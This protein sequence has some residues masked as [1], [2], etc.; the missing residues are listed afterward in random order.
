VRVFGSAERSVRCLAWSWIP[1]DCCGSVPVWAA[2]SGKALKADDARQRSDPDHLAL[3]LHRVCSIENRVE[4]KGR[5]TA[6]NDVDDA[7]ATVDPQLLGAGDVVNREFLP[8]GQSTPVRYF[9]EAQDRLVGFL[10]IRD[11]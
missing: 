6:T 5:R 1:V 8:I 4:V 10:A 11:K 9:E 3:P 2:R 7:A